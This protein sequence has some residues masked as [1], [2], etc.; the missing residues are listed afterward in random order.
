MDSETDEKSESESNQV[1]REGDGDLTKTEIC[2]KDG[3]MEQSLP[4]KSVLNGTDTETVERKEE[5]L[6]GD[7]DMKPQGNTSEE[8]DV[9]KT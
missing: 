9:E 7:V 4:G 5:K 3:V 8:I 6:G 1:K 2:E